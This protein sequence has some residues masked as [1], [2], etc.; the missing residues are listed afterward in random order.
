[1][2]YA[3]RMR[4]V[5]GPLSIIALIAASAAYVVLDGDRRG[6]G[7]VADETRLQR[8]TEFVGPRLPV[9]L[10]APGQRWRE[11]ILQGDESRIEQGLKPPGENRN[12][13]GVRPRCSTW[14]T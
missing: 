7:N 13:A 10:A 6:V 12:A 4:E 11:T 3:S 14:F 9:L 1:M 2:C 8:Q 5:A